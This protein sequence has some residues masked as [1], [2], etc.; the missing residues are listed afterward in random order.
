MSNES[1]CAAIT[2]A[3]EPYCDGY[4]EDAARLEVNVTDEYVIA[5]LFLSARDRVVITQ[6]ELQTH[7]NGCFDMLGKK[8]GEG[9]ERLGMDYVTS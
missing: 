4:C 7:L 5:L 2:K 6:G 8:L 3:F 1:V 9:R